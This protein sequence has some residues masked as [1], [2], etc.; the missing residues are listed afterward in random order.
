MAGATSSPRGRR[1]PLEREGGD[2]M[3]PLGEA[4]R[5]PRS[6][7]VFGTVVGVHEYSKAYHPY[8]V[9]RRHVYLAAEFKTKRKAKA[10]RESWSP[11]GR[12]K[13]KGGKKSQRQSCG[14]LLHA[15][16]RPSQSSSAGPISKRLDK[17]NRLAFFAARGQGQVLSGRSRIALRHGRRELRQITLRAVILRV[18]A[19]ALR[20]KGLRHEECDARDHVRKPTPPRVAVLGSPNTAATP[21]HFP[22]GRFY[23]TRWED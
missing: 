12:E 15:V 3:A 8:L 19:S 9:R 4:E 20:P 7:S 23:R 10:L 5:R 13:A 11:V 18:L 16:K 21:G 14:K 17:E 2:W 6:H 1:G 22:L